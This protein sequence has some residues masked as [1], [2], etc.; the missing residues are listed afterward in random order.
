VTSKKFLGSLALAI[1]GDKTTGREGG[2]GRG[3][4]GRG[5]EGEER[6]YMSHACY[7]LDLRRSVELDC[8]GTA[9]IQDLSKCLRV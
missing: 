6:R 5:G 9:Y 3:G 2:E 8:F 7:F 4:E 1:K